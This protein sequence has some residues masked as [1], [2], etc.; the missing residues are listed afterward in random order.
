M[1]AALA[2]IDLAQLDDVTGGYDWK[3]T[4]KA[5]L[6][7]GVAGGVAGAV[8]GAMTGPLAPATILGG[9]FVGGVTGAV[10][11]GVYDAGSQFGL[12]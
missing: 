10:G 3:R 4:G 8:G 11:A 7:G 6:G 2:T 1:Q 9:S 12:W 5:M